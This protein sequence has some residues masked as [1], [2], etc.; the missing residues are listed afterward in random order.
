M[1]RHAA[2]Q[3]HPFNQ[4]VSVLPQTGGWPVGTLEVFQLIPSTQKKLNFVNAYYQVFSGFLSFLLVHPLFAQ[5]VLSNAITVCSVCP[6]F[7]HDYK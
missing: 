3:H 2:I 1:H 7:A 4:Q 5:Y 6:V